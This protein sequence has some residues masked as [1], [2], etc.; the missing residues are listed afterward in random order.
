MKRIADIRHGL[1]STI[2]G[3]LTN[4]SPDTAHRGQDPGVDPIPIWQVEDDN[5]LNG[6]AIV[7]QPDSHNPDHDATIP[8]FDPVIEIGADVDE[9][10]PALNGN[11]GEQIRRSFEL[12]GMDALGWYSSFHVT[13][14]QWG[15]YVPITGIVYFIQNVLPGLP[16]SLNTKA[17]L[18]FHAILNHELF[19]FATDVAVAQAELVSQ[20]P[21]W[22]P[23]KHAFKQATPNYCLLEEQLANAYMLKAFRTTKPLL[24]IRGKQ[25]SLRHFTRKQPAGYRDGIRVRPQDWEKLLAALAR[26]YGKHT[27]RAAT[28][29]SLWD[30]SL[31][32]DWVAQFPILP[33]IDWR[34]CP[35]HLVRDGARLGIPPNWLT[36][37][38]RITNI[39]ETT[40]FYAELSLLAQPIQDAWK[41]TKQ[42][43][44]EAITPGTDFKPWPKAGPDVFSVRINDKI[45][46]HLQ[47]RRSANNWVAFEI[48]GHKKLGHG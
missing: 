29:P 15:I 24:R 27:G 39:T 1:I 33:K 37:F 12:H 2:H 16:A 36:F 34:Y 43:L 5:E 9:T 35:V 31:G 41:R 17:H 4:F 6:L 44:H 38:S 7:S 11:E 45:R 40:K 13:G 3:A 32:Y 48:G 26:E 21:W 42:R 8:D 30:A 10:F 23:A 25:E 22:K 20:E 47:Y 46:A 28:H 14:V 19:H 18:A